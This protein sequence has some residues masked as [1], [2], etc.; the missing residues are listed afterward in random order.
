MAAIT[1]TRTSVAP[2][3]RGADAG[4]PRP[5]AI[6]ALRGLLLAVPVGAALWVLLISLGRFAVS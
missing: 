2:E 3:H 4:R 1:P 6:S 5:E